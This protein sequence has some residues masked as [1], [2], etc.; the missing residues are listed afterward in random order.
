MAT[1]RTRKKRK[2]KKTLT[3]TSYVVMVCILAFGVMSGLLFQHSAIAE[4]NNEIR[5]LQGELEEIK[6]IN[7][8][9]EGR[10]VTNMNLQSI[11]SQ[12]RGFGMKEPVQEQYRYETTIENSR[13]SKVVNNSSIKGVIEKL[14]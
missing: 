14:F 11:E 6:Q 2:T 1:V 3:L 8:S 9:K 7:D 13:A 4:V 5:S 12:A 10:L